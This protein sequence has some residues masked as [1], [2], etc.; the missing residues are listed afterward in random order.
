MDT[1]ATLVDDEVGR[2]ASSGQERSQV[3]SIDEFVI[4][5]LRLVAETIVVGDVCGNTADPSVGVDGFGIIE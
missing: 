2:V 5:H 4:A 3:L 1:A